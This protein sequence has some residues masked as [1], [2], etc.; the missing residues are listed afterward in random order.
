MEHQVLLYC[1][2]YPGPQSIIILDNALIHK[3]ARLQELCDRS[4][5]ILEFLPPYSPDFNPIK[6][7][8][9]DLKAWIRRNYTLAAEFES[10]NSFLEFT[11]GQSYGIH[12]K[13]HFVKAGYI[14]N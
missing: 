6:A 7:T 3:S 10:F 9:K 4:S 2:P 1:T 14:I 13:A 5:V 11:I 8:F 12:A